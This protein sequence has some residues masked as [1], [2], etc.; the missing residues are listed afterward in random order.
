[1]SA[2]CVRTGLCAPQCGP[3][4]AEGV[5]LLA[6]LGVHDALECIGIE[7][8][9]VTLLDLDNVLFHKLGNVRLTVSSFRITDCP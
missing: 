6:G 7:D 1:V 4:S 5:A 9:H 2:G 8:A 3:V